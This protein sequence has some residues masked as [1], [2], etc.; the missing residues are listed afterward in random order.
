MLLI[1]STQTT[2]EVIVHPSPE[3][4][5]TIHD[6]PIP[7]PRRPDEVVIKVRAAGSN[8]EGKPP[9]PPILTLKP[10]PLSS[11]IPLLLLYAEKST[12]KFPYYT[13]LAT[14]NISPNSNSD[15][16]IASTVHA[17]GSS[18]TTI[19]IGDRVAATHRMLAPGGAYAVASVSTTF[20]VPERGMLEGA[21]LCAI[22][23]I[24]GSW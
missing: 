4:H 15:D 23:L 19:T 12:L 9:I 20:T 6:V 18:V 17:L 5:F 22:Y 13:H 1:H 7:I 8:L 21:S 10:S 11:Q 14:L 24:C 2:K 3:L 16:D